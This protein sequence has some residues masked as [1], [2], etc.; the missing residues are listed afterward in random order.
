MEENGD[1]LPDHP[2]TRAMLAAYRREVGESINEAN[3][4]ET[5]RRPSSPPQ[6]T[7]SIGRAETAAPA[8][9]ESQKKWVESMERAG[10]QLARRP[11][12]DNAYRQATRGY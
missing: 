10:E 8:L 7:R 11:A 2:E 5:P 4:P 3:Q 6:P 12:S 9:D 1:L